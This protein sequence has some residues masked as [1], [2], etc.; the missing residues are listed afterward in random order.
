M[1]RALIVTN[2]RAKILVKESWIEYETVYEKQYVGF[3]QI[4]ALYINKGVRMSISD[5][6][7]LSGHFPVYFIDAHRNIIGKIVR[8]SR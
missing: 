7:Y 2:R 6:Y 3:M 1:K 5:A 4:E 8:W